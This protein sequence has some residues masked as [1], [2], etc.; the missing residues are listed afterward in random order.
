MSYSSETTTGTQPVAPHADG[1][2]PDDVSNRLILQQIGVDL[3]RA[4]DSFRLT[5]RQAAA[6]L[7]L[8][9]SNFD[10][11]RR[12][13]TMQVPFYKVGRS[14]TYALGDLRAY[15]AQCRKGGAA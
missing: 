11:H 2:M 1:W 13:G 9:E 8:R 6:F 3:D 15:L 12:N 4:P 5:K 10:R 7:G 14:I